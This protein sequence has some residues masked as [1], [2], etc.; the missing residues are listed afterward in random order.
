MPLTDIQAHRTFFA[1]L[2]AEDPHVSA[3]TNLSYALSCLG[4][5]DKARERDA[6]ALGEADRLGLAYTQALALGL[7]FCN[8]TALTADV[9]LKRAERVIALSTEHGFPMFQ[10]L[11]TMVRG[12]CLAALGQPEEGITQLQQG[13]AIWR[14]SGAEVGIPFMFTLLADAYGKAGRPEEGLKQ[15][16][17]ASRT[18]EVRNERIFE[19][20]IHRI[21]GELLTS[22]GDFAAA[23]QSFSEALSVAQRQS[24]KLFEL[25]AAMSMARLWRDQGKRDEARELFAPV[26]RFYRRV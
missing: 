13:V 8:W 6:E 2:T 1:N 25:R 9:T 12:W 16:N 15:L 23:E 7:N 22:T 4:Y 3:A 10:L 19:T 5:A 26:Y 21:R 24:A 20:E 17:E 11:A 14:S 18:M